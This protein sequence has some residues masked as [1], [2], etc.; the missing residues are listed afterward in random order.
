[1]SAEGPGG[2]RWD[3]ITVISPDESVEKADEH[4]LSNALLESAV[5]GQRTDEHNRRYQQRGARK[6]T[7]RDAH[8]KV[9]L[10]IFSLTSH[11]PLATY[12]RNVFAGR[13]V[14]LSRIFQILYRNVGSYMVD[15]QTNGGEGGLRGCVRPW[16]GY[17]R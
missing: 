6:C 14:T 10:R 12:S 3:L 13:S 5:R 15:E 9:S 17:P 11:G 16:R 4:V 8:R 2:Q 1:M 7:D